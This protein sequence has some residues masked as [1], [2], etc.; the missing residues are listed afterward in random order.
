MKKNR[1]H[2]IEFRLAF[3]AFKNTKTYATIS[4]YIQHSEKEL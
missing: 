2:E 1:M 3:V 4:D